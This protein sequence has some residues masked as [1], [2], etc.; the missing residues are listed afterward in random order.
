MSATVDAI[1]ESGS[2]RL[3]RALSLPEHTRVRIHVE[4]ISSDPEREAWLEQSEQGL[5]RVW[6]NDADDVYNDLLAP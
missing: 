1:Y 4:S 6:E 3:L 2:L 5:Q